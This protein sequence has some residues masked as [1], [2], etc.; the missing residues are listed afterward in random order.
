M[1]TIVDCTMTCLFQLAEYVCNRCS[2]TVQEPVSPQKVVLTI[3]FTNEDNP[4][5][6]KVEAVEGDLFK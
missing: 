2:S 5:H 6:S 1:E 3:R 4:L